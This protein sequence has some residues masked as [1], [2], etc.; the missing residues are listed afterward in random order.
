MD[1]EYGPAEAEADAGTRQRRGV[2]R[3][4]ADT[5]ETRLLDR[6]DSRISTC[7]VLL[8][9]FTGIGFAQ[10][11]DAMAQPAQQACT[12]LA[13]VKNGSWS[14]NSAGLVRPLFTLRDGEGTVTIPEPF[15]R[16]AG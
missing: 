4:D 15:C 2:F 13:K 7:V 8:F 5:V 11:A 12:D 6:R 10:P 1:H 3:E 9:V 14:V 16:V